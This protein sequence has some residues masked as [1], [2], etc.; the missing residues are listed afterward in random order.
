MVVA[1][2]KIVSN[3][4]R[5]AGSHLSNKSLGSRSSRSDNAKRRMRR[6]KLTQ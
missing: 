1:D 2:N 6:I 3:K 5:N 4:S